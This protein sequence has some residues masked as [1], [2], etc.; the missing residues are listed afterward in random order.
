MS[1]SSIDYYYD[2][3]RSVFQTTVRHS[4]SVVQCYLGNKQGG[5]S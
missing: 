3:R 5:E 4:A 2:S 1:S